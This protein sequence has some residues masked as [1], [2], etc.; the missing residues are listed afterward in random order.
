VHHLRA[1]RKPYEKADM[2]QNSAHGGLGLLQCAWTFNP[3]GPPRGS[4][5]DEMKQNYEHERD[6]EYASHACS[7]HP[8][9][10][11]TRDDS[12]FPK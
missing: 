7:N 5:L 11:T 1:R 10:K 4:D 6:K 8:R 3:S 12:K 2:D 9:A